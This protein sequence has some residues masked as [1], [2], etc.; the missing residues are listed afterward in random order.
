MEDMHK[1]DTLEEDKLEE[2]KFEEERP[3]LLDYVN[4]Q[5]E[6]HNFNFIAWITA[7]IFLN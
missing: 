2:D 6:L 1:E 3:C 4:I 5:K 7:L